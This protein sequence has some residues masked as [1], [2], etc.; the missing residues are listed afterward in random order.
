MDGDDRDEERFVDE[1]GSHFVEENRDEERFD[2]VVGN[3]SVEESRGGERCDDQ[4]V[5]GIGNENGA[6][7]GEG[8]EAGVELRI[9]SE[10]NSTGV[11]GGWWSWGSHLVAGGEKQ[12]GR[13]FEDW[14]VK[15]G[16]WEDRTLV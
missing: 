16:H 5:E 2:A 1:E 15:T 4:S 11:G 9:Q 13:F 7:W 10:D 14:K 12:W 8:G 6:G 3:H